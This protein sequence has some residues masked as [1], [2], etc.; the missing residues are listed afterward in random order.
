MS[1]LFKN[2]ETNTHPEHSALK[3]KLAEVYTCWQTFCG[4]SFWNIFCL[5]GWLL[6]NFQLSPEMAFGPRN[7]HTHTHVRPFSNGLFVVKHLSV[8]DL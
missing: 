6:P 1:I 7:S 5:S 4:F 2:L 3:E 8:P